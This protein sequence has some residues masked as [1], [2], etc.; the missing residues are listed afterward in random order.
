MMGYFASSGFLTM[1]LKFSMLSSLLKLS[2]TPITVLAVGH[3]CNGKVSRITENCYSSR[4][5]TSVGKFLSTSPWNEDYILRALQ[6]FALKK[7]IAIIKR[8][9]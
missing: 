4:H 9:R 5:R 3:G 8:Y 2:V 6:K 7:N 1:R